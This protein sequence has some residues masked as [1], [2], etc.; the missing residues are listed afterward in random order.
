MPDIQFYI[1]LLIL[2]F[3]TFELMCRILLIAL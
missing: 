1:A 3:M 2:S